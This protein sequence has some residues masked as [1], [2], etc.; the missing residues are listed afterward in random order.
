MLQ[1]VSIEVPPEAV[2]PSVEF[3]AVL[4]FERIEEPEQ[5][6]GNVTWFERRGTH[7]HL[8]H[9]AAATVP[10]LG[11]CAVAVEDFD[12]ALAGLAEASHE[13]TETRQLWGARRAFAVAPGGHR[14]ELMEFPPAWPEPPRS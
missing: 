14:V 4:G 9:T 12:R 1:H 3:W 13:V 8:I 11:H 6:R 10:Q 7:V 2:E 5:L